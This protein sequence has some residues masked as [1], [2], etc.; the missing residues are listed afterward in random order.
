MGLHEKRCGDYGDTPDS[1]GLTWPRHVR[2]PA[3]RSVGIRA[4]GLPAE[5]IGSLEPA[6]M[7]LSSRLSN[8]RL[9]CIVP[10]RRRVQCGERKLVCEPW[11]KPVEQGILVPK[12]V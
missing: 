12:L 3:R 2:L 7:L 4:A 11:A 5:L 8:A 9:P 10:E 1:A 6:G